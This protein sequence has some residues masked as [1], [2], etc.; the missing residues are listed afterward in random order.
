MRYAIYKINSDGEASECLGYIYDWH[1]MYDTY[2][3][4]ME[5]GVILL[6]PQEDE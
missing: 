4:M 2:C 5:A 3:Q 1:W 6:V